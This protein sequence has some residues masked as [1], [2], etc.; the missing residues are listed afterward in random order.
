MHVYYYNGRLLAYPPPMLTASVLFYQ[1][2]VVLPNQASECHIY[3]THRFISELNSVGNI[4]SAVSEG[5][6]IAWNSMLDYVWRLQ[7][8]L[9]AENFIREMRIGYFGRLDSRA[10]AQC[11]TANTLLVQSVQ[12]R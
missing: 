8:S 3:Q 6:G 2:P 9:T 1:N 5:N 11:L 12:P 4:Q 10:Q 7:P